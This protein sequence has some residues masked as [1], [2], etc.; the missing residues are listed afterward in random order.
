MKTKHLILFL[1]ALMVSMMA[2]A[3]TIDNINYTLNSTNRTAIVASQSKSLSG[4]IQIPSS[5][6]YE[7]TPYNVTGIQYDAFRNCQNITSVI[8]PNTVTEIGN[9]AFEGCSL[10]N[11]I[12]IPTSISVIRSGTFEGC[13]NL[14]SITLPQ[15][16]TEIQEYAFRNCTFLT[17]ITIP[18]NVWTIGRYPVFNRG[19]YTDD[20][21]EGSEPG[22]EDYSHYQSPFN[23]CTSL[24]SFVV[25]EDNPYFSSVD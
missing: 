12:Y 13:T 24:K 9:R 7:N 4:N 16:I 20:W 17:S 19:E 18:E 25:D 3:V 11:Y 2:N 8:I 6:T 22:D 1:L 14:T 23:G 21:V 5:V 15:S 10:L